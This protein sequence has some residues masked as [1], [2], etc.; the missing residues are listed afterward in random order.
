MWSLWDWTFLWSHFEIILLGL[1]HFHFKLCHSK[2]MLTLVISKLFMQP[3][4]FKIVVNDHS[5]D[6]VW[7]GSTSCMVFLELIW[8]KTTSITVLMFPLLFLVTHCKAVLFQARLFLGITRLLSRT[9][10]TLLLKNRM[11]CTA[12]YMKT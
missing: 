9:K 6:R 1:N 8:K 7:H 2:I 11:H 12:I 5:H 10:S 4:N 3:T